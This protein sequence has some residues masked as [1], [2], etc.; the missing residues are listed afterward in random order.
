MQRHTKNRDTGTYNI[1][2]TG[3]GLSDLFS[4]IASA[5][6]R[7]TA[8]NIRKKASTKVAEKCAEKIGEKTGQVVGEKIYDKFSKKGTGIKKPVIQGKGW[9]IAKIMKSMS[10][11]SIF[12]MVLTGIM[13]ILKLIFMSAKEQIINAQFAAADNIAII[14]EAQ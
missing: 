12:V 13:C 9:E 4:K 1:H 14:K 7:K 11:T 6:A 5:V 8:Q 10:T 3:E 2:Q